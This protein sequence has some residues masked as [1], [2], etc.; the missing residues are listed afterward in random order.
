MNQVIYK[1][2][3]NFKNCTLEDEE[4]LFELK[5]QNFKIYVEEI[6]GG[7]DKDQKKRLEDDLKEHLSHK[8]IIM[9]NDKK[10]RCICYSYNR[11]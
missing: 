10:V 4:F 3:Y 9:I 8:K 5:K 11:K 1:M 7:D 6:W 2:K